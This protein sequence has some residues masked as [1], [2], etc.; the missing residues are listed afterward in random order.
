M[1]VGLVLDPA[2]R[3][4]GVPWLGKN[5]S[6]LRVRLMHAREAAKDREGGREA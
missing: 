4:S 1:S 3:D 6:R 5:P 2:H